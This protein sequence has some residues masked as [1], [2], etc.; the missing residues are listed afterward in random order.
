MS[1]CS[2]RCLLFL[3]SIDNLTL[4]SPLVFVKLYNMISLFSRKLK[5]DVL[6]SAECTIGMVWGLT[7][8]KH[9][10]NK[11]LNHYGTMTI[12]CKL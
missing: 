3:V 5:G 6:F 1:T 4:L 10:G 12:W 7:A 9:Y 2:L 11:A 8:I